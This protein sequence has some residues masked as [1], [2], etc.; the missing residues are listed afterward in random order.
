MDDRAQNCP[1][2]ELPVSP[3][4]LM[5]TQTKAKG[6]NIFDLD[7]DQLDRSTG[8][9]AFIGSTANSWCRCVMGFHVKTCLFYV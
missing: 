4:D 8:V 1:I 5:Y 7:L 9:K 2:N 3:C 6:N